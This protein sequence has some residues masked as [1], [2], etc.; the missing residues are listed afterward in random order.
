MRRASALFLWYLFKTENV[1]FLRK[2]A[3]YFVQQDS[4]QQEEKSVKEEIDK[5]KVHKYAKR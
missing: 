3:F 4:Q 1:F 2:Q 5:L